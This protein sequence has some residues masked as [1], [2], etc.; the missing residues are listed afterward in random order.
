MSI[1][2]PLRVSRQRPGY[3]TPAG[4]SGFY[5]WLEALSGIELQTRLGWAYLAVH[6][7]KA[8]VWFLPDRPHPREPIW[9]FALAYSSLLRTLCFWGQ[10][11]I[12]DHGILCHMAWESLW[13]LTLD[14]V[15]RLK[16]NIF[17]TRCLKLGAAFR[18]C[19]GS[20]SAPASLFRP[21][22]TKN[23]IR[24]EEK[25]GMVVGMGRP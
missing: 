10:V 11:T 19:P 13:L 5:S 25:L 22:T 20:V 21:L 18:K 4:C 12:C 2:L 15:L 14:I 3:N 16:Q 17:R 1:W 7:D 24:N 6:N 23:G 9:V 8:L